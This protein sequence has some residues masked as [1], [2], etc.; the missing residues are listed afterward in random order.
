M[1]ARP[2]SPCLHGPDRSNSSERVPVLSAPCLVLLVSSWTHTY[3]SL[4]DVHSASRHQRRQAREAS[5]G[6]TGRRQARAGATSR[7]TR[8]EIS[9][10]M[11]RGRVAGSTAR[12]APSIGSSGGRPSAG[13][14]P[15]SSCT[16]AP[17]ARAAVRL[18][19]CTRRQ[20]G[21]P[22]QAVESA[23]CAALRL[24][25]VQQPGHPVPR[26]TPA[27]CAAERMA[28]AHWQPGRP[29]LCA[30]RPA[31]CRMRC[32][33]VGLQ[34]C[35]ACMRMGSAARTWLECCGMLVPHNVFI[36]ALCGLT[37]SRATGRKTAACYFTNASCKR[38]QW[39]YSGTQGGKLRR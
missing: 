27:A 3:N 30:V 11:G 36:A 12:A 39:Q 5:R 38:A 20:P 7:W 28:D 13:P 32:Q 15:S 4:R 1:R 17:A 35:Q 29:E 37:S 22:V 21:R 24:E 26:A 33:V 10:Q 18:A 31:G 25:R 9:E 2:Q 16:D 19:A 34:H 14:G 23:A 8:L 6:G